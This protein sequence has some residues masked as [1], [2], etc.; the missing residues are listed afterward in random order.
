MGSVARSAEHRPQTRLVLPRSVQARL[1]QVRLAQLR[2]R[3]A[4]MVVTAEVVAMMMA[5]RL[6]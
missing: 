3:A 5:A 6:R 4:V 1:G 2:R